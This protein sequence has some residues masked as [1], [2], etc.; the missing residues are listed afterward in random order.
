MNG[1]QQEPAVSM[2]RHPEQPMEEVLTAGICVV[3]AVSVRSDLLNK[4]MALR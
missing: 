4:K 2:E 3:R 1:L